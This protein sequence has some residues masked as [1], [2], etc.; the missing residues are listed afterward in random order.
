MERSIHTKQITHLS[1]LAK[2]YLKSIPNHPIDEKDIKPEL[3]NDLSET[4]SKQSRTFVTY[5]M[6]GHGIEELY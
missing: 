5:G 6:S 2:E 3:D 4:D 1:P